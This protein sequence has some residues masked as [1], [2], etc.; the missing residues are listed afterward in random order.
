VTIADL[1]VPYKAQGD[2][3]RALSRLKSEGI[4][5]EYHLIGGGDPSRLEIVS[6]NL[7]VES[8]IIIHGTIPHENIFPMLRDMDLYV[9]PSRTEGL[10]RA[11]VESFCV[12][13]PSI[14]SRVGGIPELLPDHRLFTPG[15]IDEIVRLVKTM[16][17]SEALESDAVQNWNRAHDFQAS[18]LD[19]RRSTFFNNFL[20][21]NGLS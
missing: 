3:I 5:C 13:L 11:V 6:R 10:P 12:A 17:S 19:E 14:G 2:V 18:L 4:S 8:Q 16:H 20:E 1:N 21:C 7:A 15:S 9:H